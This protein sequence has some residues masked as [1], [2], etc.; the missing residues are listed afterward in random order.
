MDADAASLVVA[1]AVVGLNLKAAMTFEA[2]DV[3]SGAAAAAAAG[4]VSFFC[5]P[6]VFFWPST[7]SS[8]TMNVGSLKHNL[9]I[10][11]NLNKLTRVDKV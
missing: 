1:A 5:C 2:S 10:A 3:F 11:K 7:P 4:G 6:A 9:T 8:V